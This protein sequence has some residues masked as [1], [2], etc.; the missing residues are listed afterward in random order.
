MQNF[1]EMIVESW[2]NFH[3]G[4][5]G[6]TG[7]PLGVSLCNDVFDLHLLCNYVDLVPGVDTIGVGTPVKDSVMPFAVENITGRFSARPRR[8]RT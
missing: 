4:R 8:M 2:N 1:I 5:A 6:R 3:E 7:H